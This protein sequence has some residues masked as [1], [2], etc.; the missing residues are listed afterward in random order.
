MCSI[1]DD[2]CDILIAR[3]QGE[4]LDSPT[5]EEPDSCGWVTKPKPTSD[6]QFD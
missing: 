3:E 6:D 1:Y 5:F 2:P 4:E